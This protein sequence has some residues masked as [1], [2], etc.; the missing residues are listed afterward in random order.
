MKP[1]KGDLTECSFE[2]L[3]PFQENW[4][5]FGQIEPFFGRQCHFNR[6]NRHLI[7]HSGMADAVSV[8]RNEGKCQK[9]SCPSSPN[10]NAGLG[11]GDTLHVLNR[12]PAHL[13]TGK[14]KQTLGSPSQFFLKSYQ[15]E[16]LAQEHSILVRIFG[17]QHHSVFNFWGTLYT[18]YTK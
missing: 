4:S 5:F 2:T 6:Q 14:L 13:A 15:W 3:I 18:N 1:T 10:S 9:R 16:N 12:Q 11:R 8:Q 17:L 7:D